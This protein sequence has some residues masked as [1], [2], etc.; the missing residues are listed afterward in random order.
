MTLKAIGG[1]LP[2]ETVDNSPACAA[3]GRDPAFLSDKLGFLSRRRKA[4]AESVTDMSVCAIEDL[5]ARC[6]VDRTRIGLLVVVTQNPGQNIPHAAALVHE[7]L[8]LPRDCM[9]FDL[10]QGCAGYIHGLAVAES[11]MAS[12][13]IEHTILV[14][15]D[16]YSTIVDPHDLST[17]LIFGD[18]ATATWLSRDGP[19]FRL[20][21]ATFGTAPDSSACLTRQPGGSLFMDG[22]Q[23]LSNVV[24]EV[25]R[26]LRGLMNRNGLTNA[27]VACF[28][29]H[30]A[31]RHAIEKLRDLL[32]VNEAQAP[33]A[34]QRIGNTVSSSIPLLIQHRI[35]ARE[36]GPI[37]AC[38]FGV[39]F[40]WGAGLLMPNFKQ[41]RASS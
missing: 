13:S 3:F 12:Q 34:A 15:C 16:P 5:E 36:H 11:L 23:V 18:A 4:E 27:D 24:H 37:V 41:E 31:S 6:D 9:T 7:R 2:A 19:G 17:A 33:F 21:D 32:G 30:Q 14:T 40:S 28:A 20:S 10:S 29:L 1:Y 38:G 8:G 26:A 39:G 22:R 25:P 35:N